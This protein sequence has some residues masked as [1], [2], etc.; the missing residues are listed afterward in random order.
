MNVEMSLCPSRAR[1][2]GVGGVGEHGGGQM[3]A[4]DRLPGRRAAAQRAVV[5]RVAE[6]AE[7]AGHPLGAQ[8]AVRAGL[9]QALEQQPIAVVDGV[10]ED[11]EVLIAR[12]HR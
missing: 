12:V 6:V 8:F 9:A 1:P 3:G 10:A 5:D 7:Q 11:V 2:L 4:A